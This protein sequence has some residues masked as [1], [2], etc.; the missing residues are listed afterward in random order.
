MWPEVVLL[1]FPGVVRVV[2]AV[3]AGLGL[4]VWAAG[5]ITVIRAFDR[6]ELLTTGVF[7]VV[8]HPVYAGW[9]SLIF[10]GLGLFTGA[11]PLFL[12]S[13]LD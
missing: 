13:L 10:P 8:R 7:S 9:I 5:A 11:W 1:R 4:L 6:G 3:L 12:I 2:G